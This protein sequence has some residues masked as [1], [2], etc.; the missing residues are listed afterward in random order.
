[1]QEAEALEQGGVPGTVHAD[2]AVLRAVAGPASDPDRHGSAGPAWARAV[3]LQ[4]LR[5]G[6]GGLGSAE[7]LPR[8]GRSGSG[9][10]PV[11]PTAAG[12]LAPAGPRLEGPDDGPDAEAAVGR[13]RS[14]KT[15]CGVWN[16]VT[17]ALI[18]T[19][20]GAALASSAEGACSGSSPE[21]HPRRG[22]LLVP[23]CA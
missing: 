16:I 10:A 5:S 2:P 22:T 4:R 14:L 19:A 11:E 1:M 13:R 3:G 9:G 23:S 17:E 12:P 6:G 8:P 15:A 20:A 7:F 21:L 18:P